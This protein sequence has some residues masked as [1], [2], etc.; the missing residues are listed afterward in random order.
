MSDQES[1]LFFSGYLRSVSSSW[2]NAYSSSSPH[3]CSLPNQRSYRPCPS[4]HGG[5]LQPPRF[6]PCSVSMKKQSQTEGK[7]QQHAD[8]FVL[9]QNQTRLCPVCSDAAN[10]ISPSP[11]IPFSDF[12]N[13][14]LDHIDFMEDYQTWQAHGN[15]NRCGRK[16]YNSNRV[17]L[18]YLHFPVLS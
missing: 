5:S 12:Y 7:V 9:G 15:S 13:L 11:I 8:C 3:V 17:M 6:S 4:A 16:K 1:F 14:T 2:W 10:S 18:Q